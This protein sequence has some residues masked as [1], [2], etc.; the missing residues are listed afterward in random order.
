M[1][2]TQDRPTGLFE[3]RPP[4]LLPWHTPEREALQQQARR[5]ARDPAP[6]V[7]ALLR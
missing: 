3:P 4:A 6:T 1:T 7:P 2:S 5:F